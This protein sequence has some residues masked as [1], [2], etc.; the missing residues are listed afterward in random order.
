VATAAVA[1][2]VAE[3]ALARHGILRL[4]SERRPAPGLRVLSDD[5]GRKLAAKASTVKVDRAALSDRLA[6]L[7][8]NARRIL[9]NAEKRKTVAAAN[10]MA[11]NAVDKPPLRRIGA[12]AKKSGLLSTAI[13][14]TK[15]IGAPA[16]GLRIRL[17]DAT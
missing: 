17:E 4:G 6:G 14:S 8:R 5:A 13:A 15:I 2:E 16:R 3:P 7:H 11:G 10:V 9:A 12:D 1:A